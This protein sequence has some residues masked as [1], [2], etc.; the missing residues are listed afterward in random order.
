MICFGFLIGYTINLI[1]FSNLAGKNELDL[2]SLNF[3]LQIGVAT[4]SKKHHVDN[5]DFLAR[6]YQLG[7][8]VTGPVLSYLHPL[9]LLY[10]YW[11]WS[12]RHVHL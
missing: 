6:D 1:G 5:S 12:L 11:W 8:A 2:F 3:E 7:S 4:S 9:S 10:A